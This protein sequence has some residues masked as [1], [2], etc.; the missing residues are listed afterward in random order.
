MRPTCTAWPP[1]RL[2]TISGAIRF[3]ARASS[4]PISVPEHLPRTSADFLPA[5]GALRHGGPPAGVLQQMGFAMSFNYVKAAVCAATMTC[6]A[7]TGAQAHI[8]LDTREAVGTV[9]YGDQT[10]D[11]LVS[12]QSFRTD[13]ISSADERAGNPEKASAP[14]GA[15]K[16]T[17]PK[18]PA[19]V[20]DSFAR[21]KRTLAPTMVT[22]TADGEPRFLHSLDVISISLQV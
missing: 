11:A 1:S 14:K 21:Q 22:E 15:N 3:L 13:G 20:L 10:F 8:V 19:S 12:A 9:S 7:V 4:L 16:A 5:D 2:C 6:A 18:K 17:S